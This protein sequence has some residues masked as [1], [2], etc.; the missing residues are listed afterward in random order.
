V[1]ELLTPKEKAE[2]LDSFEIQYKLITRALNNART[3][4]ATTKAKW[5]RTINRKLIT[6]LEAMQLEN[7]EIRHDILTESADD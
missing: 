5:I 3:I 7:V 1:F 4:V 6:Q 2:W